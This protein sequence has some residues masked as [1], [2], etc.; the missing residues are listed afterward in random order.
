M[1][2]QIGQER[3][4]TASRKLSLFCDGD[5]C[6]EHYEATLTESVR[7]ARRSARIYHGWGY[8]RRGAVMV[9]LCPA[10]YGIH[11][12]GGQDEPQEKAE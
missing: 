4:M 8:V 10:C 6:Y 5:D 12:K 1:P 3:I 7:E 9:D 2:A 11:K